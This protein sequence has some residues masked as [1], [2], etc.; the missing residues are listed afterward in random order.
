M[1]EVDLS[2][3]TTEAVEAARPRAE[4]KDL[5]LETATQAVPAMA[6]DH[7]RLAQV[8]DNLISNAVKFTPQG[9][10]VSVRLAVHNGEAAL[11]VRDTGVG[12]P[13][14]EQDRLFERF[15]RATT[16]TERAIPGVGLGLTIAKAIV[17]AHG[18]NLDFESVEGSGTTFTVRLPL[19]TPP[20]G[21]PAGERLR[22][23]VSL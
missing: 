17:E 18:G 13:A 21:S 20:S 22:G 2:T 10:T 1:S 16:A 12:I 6:G 3:L 4:A 5:A 11:E 23:G 14:A 19:R 9:G 15:Y 7:D 8:L